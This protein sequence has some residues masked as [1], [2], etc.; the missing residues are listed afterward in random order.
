MPETR[1]AKARKT[2]P[3]GYQF[4]TAK[5]QM[6]YVGICLGCHNSINSEALAIQHS[7]GCGPVV[8]GL[9]EAWE[10]QIG[11]QVGRSILT[12]CNDWLRTR[13]LAL[14]RDGNVYERGHNDL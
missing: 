4:P 5:S 9:T 13:G 6:R 7:D 10:S 12:D 14:D 1:L 8:G 11:H 2:L 3:E